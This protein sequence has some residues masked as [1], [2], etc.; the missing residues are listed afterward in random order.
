LNI[1][2]EKAVRAIALMQ[3]AGWNPGSRV[4]GVHPG[5]GG[6]TKCWPVDRYFALI[7][8]VQSLEDLFLIFFTGREDDR[9]L[10]QKVSRFAD[11]RN[12]VLLADGLDLS[13]AAA[14]LSRCTFYIGND[15][16]FSHLAG[17][18][19]CSA[20][21]LFG[22][23]DP[24]CWKPVGPRVHVLAPEKSGPITGISAERVFAAAASLIHGFAR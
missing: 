3:E 16:G 10:A 22:P 12:N 21:V 15:S 6:K 7:E 18:L 4:M 17:M 5:S 1:P 11:G 9:E 19:G 2:K 14:L 24:A 23:T 20:L 8:R 13:G